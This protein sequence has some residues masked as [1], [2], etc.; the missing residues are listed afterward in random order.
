MEFDL[1][2]QNVDLL[3]T[4]PLGGL[5]AQFKLAP[6]MRLRY[7][8]NKIKANNPKKAASDRQTLP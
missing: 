2:L 8:A 3:R 5:Q 6:E 7:D 4:K 1:F